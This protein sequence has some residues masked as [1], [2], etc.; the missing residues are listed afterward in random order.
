[1][2]IKKL[3]AF[4]AAAVGLSVGGYALAK[5]ATAKSSK[6]VAKKTQHTTKRK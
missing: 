5:K 1:M 6:K 2:K 3:L 4:L